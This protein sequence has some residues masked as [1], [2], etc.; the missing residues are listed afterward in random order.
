MYNDKGTNSIDGFRVRTRKEE[1]VMVVLVKLT[2]IS[3][4]YHK[5]TVHS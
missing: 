2:M 4:G 3:A 1:A 5:H